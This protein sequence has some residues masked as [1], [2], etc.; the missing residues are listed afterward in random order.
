MF[1]Q[2]SRAESPSTRDVAKLLE[3][4]EG[5]GAV[6]AADSGT[7]ATQE[8]QGLLPEMAEPLGNPWFF[9]R[10]FSEILFFSHG[11]PSKI[12]VFF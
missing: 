8:T 5:A 11:F 4:L 2:V 12:G 1:P 6:A 10:C 7:G 3:D 9:P